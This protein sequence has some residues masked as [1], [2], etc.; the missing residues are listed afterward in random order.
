MLKADHPCLRADYYR[1]TNI[2]YSS[3]LAPKD[4]TQLLRATGNTGPWKK[5]N[6]KVHLHL[7]LHAAKASTMLLISP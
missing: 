7:S 4:T 1:R 5:K 6:Q 2:A 3:V